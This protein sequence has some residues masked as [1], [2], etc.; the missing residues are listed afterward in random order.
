MKSV[1]KLLIQYVQIRMKTYTQKSTKI[2]ATAHS[3]TV[4]VH[5]QNRMRIAEK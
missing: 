2:A 4:G 5:Y 1:H 3:N